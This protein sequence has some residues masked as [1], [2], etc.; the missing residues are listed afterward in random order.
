MIL[1][2]FV[3]TL[4]CQCHNDNF[5]RSNLQFIIIIDNLWLMSSE[6]VVAVGTAQ[7]CLCAAVQF[8]ERVPVR[9][10]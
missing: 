5:V 9:S 7:M 4:I 1:K 8:V 10:S 2:S 3:L 6:I